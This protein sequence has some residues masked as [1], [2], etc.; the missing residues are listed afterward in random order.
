MCPC[1]SS[2]LL[3]SIEQIVD[4]S[5]LP[6]HIVDEQHNTPTEVRLA[7]PCFHVASALYL[8]RAAGLGTKR[9]HMPA[10]LYGNPARDSDIDDNR[11]E[12]DFKLPK[13][14]LQSGSEDNLSVWTEKGGPAIAPIGQCVGEHS[15][16]SVHIGATVAFAQFRFGGI[17]RVASV[18]YCFFVAHWGI[19]TV[20]VVVGA[21]S[22]PST[23]DF[24]IMSTSN[25]IHKRLKGAQDVGGAD[26][27]RPRIVVTSHSLPTLTLMNRDRCR[28]RASR[29]GSY[30][31]GINILWH[32]C[33][34][35]PA[36]RLRVTETPDPAEFD[37]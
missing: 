34:R 36:D 7:G 1:F 23:S 3:W 32:H 15:Q 31:C 21:G 22:L 24:S 19:H 25:A 27:P 11:T 28:P 13:Q 12:L 20:V 33:K 8:Y 10:I 29:R 2:G 17:D 30:Q 9:H 26:S 6:V 14:I 18:G 5:G 4:Q 37:F 16:Y 35:P